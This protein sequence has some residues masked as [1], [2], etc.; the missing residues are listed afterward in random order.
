MIYTETGSKFVFET[1]VKYKPCTQYQVK[2]WEV[3]WQSSEEIQTSP[4]KTQALQEKIYG[5]VFG[6]IQA[7]L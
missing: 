4:S 7:D 1:Q 6:L 3:M 2:D 5:Q